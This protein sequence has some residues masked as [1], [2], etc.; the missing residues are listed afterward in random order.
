MSA[1][2]KPGA[3]LEPHHHLAAEGKLASESVWRW[4][5]GWGVC[6]RAAP[7]H[8]ALSSVL[9]SL[10]HL[11]FLAATRGK[12]AKLWQPPLTWHKQHH[13]SHFQQLPPYRGCSVQRPGPSFVWFQCIHSNQGLKS[14]QML[15]RL[16]S[17][18]SLVL[19]LLSYKWMDT[20]TKA[21]CRDRG[22]AE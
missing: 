21:A 19:A 22:Q 10:R 18:D 13:T 11:C 14:V 12:N 5:Q 17:A 9:F 7:D 4:L 20:H 3:A 16:F 15:R 2:P 6:V 8:S 1:A